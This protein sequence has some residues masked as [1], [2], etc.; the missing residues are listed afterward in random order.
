MFLMTII[1]L[2]LSLGLDTLIVSITLG[3]L[4]TKGRLKIAITFALAEAIMA[5]I[6]LLLG[7]GLGHWL[8]RYTSI[9]G[10]LALL[11]VAIWMLFFEDDD[12]ALEKVD[13]RTLS[14][15]LLL[16]TALSISIDEIAVGFSI[17]IVGVPILVTSVIVGAQALLFSLLGLYFGQ[18]LKPYVGEWAEKAAG[19]VIGLLGLWI[20]FH[21]L[22]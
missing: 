19:I 20:L 7:Q 13:Q 11:G 10:G 16:L 15:R 21:A 22:L 14:G 8:G 17:G 6:G 4:E 1:V 18:K 3:M 5:L 12:E 9:I 2:I